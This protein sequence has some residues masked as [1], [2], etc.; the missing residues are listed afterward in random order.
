MEGPAF[1]RGGSIEWFIAFS[2]YNNADVDFR[3]GS[4][5]GHGFLRCKKVRT[6]RIKSHPRPRIAKLSLVDPGRSLHQIADRDSSFG[7]M[8]A[9]SALSFVLIDQM[10]LP[11]PS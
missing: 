5:F 8:C 6:K 4:C 1:R 3:A 9:L 11:L 10:R 7:K 2:S